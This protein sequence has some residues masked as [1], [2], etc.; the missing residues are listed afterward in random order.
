MNVEAMFAGLQAGELGDDFDA[1]FLLRERD[2][3]FDFVIAKAVDDGDG[4]A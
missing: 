1:V 4:H 2:F 3:A